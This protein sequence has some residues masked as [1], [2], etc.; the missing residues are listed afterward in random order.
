VKKLGF[1]LLVLVFAFGALGVGY[2]HWSQT[3]YIEGKVESGTFMTGFGEAYCVDEEEDLPDPKDVGTCVAELDP[4]SF[5]A[6]KETPLGPKPFY[7][8]I[9]VTIDNAYPSYWAH[10][11]FTIGNLG[12]I[13]A[14]VTA[15][16]LTDPTGELGFFWY[17]PPPATPAYGEFWKD[18]NGNGVY[19]DGEEVLNVVLVN[20]VGMQLHPCTETKGELD[21]HLKQTAEQ[22]HQYKFL[23]EIDTIQWNFD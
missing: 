15:F 8:K 13:P 4:D 19:D 12:T 17:T 22:A 9:I 6:F 14:H 20:F 21:L 1:L 5:L 3:L 23:V 7:E 10:V 11:V 2:A 16:R 18:Y